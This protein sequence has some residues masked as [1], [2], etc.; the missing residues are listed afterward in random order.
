[1]PEFE[2]K[3]KALSS[4]DLLRCLIELSTTEFYT[5]IR[6]LLINE[7]K[8]FP[9]ILIVGLA[10]I[11]PRRGNSLHKELIEL[12]LPTYIQPSTTNPIVL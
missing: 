7:A 6:N 2:N 3:I 9:D 5:L 12:L 1:L 10:I 11:K 8:D 4:L